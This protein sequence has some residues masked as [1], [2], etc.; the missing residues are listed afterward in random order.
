MLCGSLDERGV[1]GRMDTCVCM[2][3]SLHCSPGTAT[4]LLINYNTKQKVF[5]MQ[6]DFH[7]YTFW[8]KEGDKYPKMMCSK[9]TV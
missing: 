9:N 5:L 3:E 7:K 1:W 2:S 8:L 4:T 6:I